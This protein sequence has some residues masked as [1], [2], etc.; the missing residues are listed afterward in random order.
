MTTK[1]M[2]LLIAWEGL[3]LNAYLDTS[4]IPTIGIGST[5]YEN[6]QPVK[7]GDTI[8]SEEAIRLCKSLVDSVFEKGVRDNLRV[9]LQPNQVDALT[10]LCYNIGVE[11]FKNSTVLRLINSGSPRSDVEKAWKMW[12]MSK[13]EILQGLVNRREAELAY[14]FSHEPVPVPAMAAPTQSIEQVP[15]PEITQEQPSGSRLDFLYSPSFWSMFIGAI[16][17]MMGEDGIFTMPEIY[18]GLTTLAG[19]FTAVYL[20]DKNLK[21]FADAIKSRV[22]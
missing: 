7:M 12:R 1:G 11:A 16:A 4:G 13:G 14:Y 15:V 20:A 5:F 3:R 18:K 19:G 9:E 6:G 10:S 8:T 17:I 2:D 21:R 22:K